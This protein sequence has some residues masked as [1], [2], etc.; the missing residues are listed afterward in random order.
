[1]EKIKK[2]QSKRVSMP[3]NAIMHTDSKGNH[4]EWL[5]QRSNFAHEQTCTYCNAY[6]VFCQNKYFNVK[7]NKWG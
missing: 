2:L 1:M 7:F 3:L 5:L 4:R 6:L